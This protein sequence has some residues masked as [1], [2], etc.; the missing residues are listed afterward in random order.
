MSLPTGN[1]SVTEVNKRSCNFCGKVLASARNVKNHIARFHVDDVVA[2]DGAM[3]NFSS[4]QVLF[5]YLIF[6]SLIRIFSCI[7]LY[8]TVLYCT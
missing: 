5:M 8:L 2:S 3:D 4:G 6:L 1:I 7:I